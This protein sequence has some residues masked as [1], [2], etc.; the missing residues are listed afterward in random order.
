MARA[1]D[2]HETMVAVNFDDDANFRW[3][4][5]ILAHRLDDLRWVALS[6]DL[7]VLVLDLSRHIVVPVSRGAPYPARIAGNVYSTDQFDDAAL[8]TARQ[9][10]AALADVLRPAG[11]GAAG[12][13]AAAPALTMEWRFADTAFEKFGEIVPV[14]ISR[15]ALRMVIKGSAG[16]AEVEDN[17]ERFWTFVERVGN[18]DIE[19]WREEKTSGRGRDPRIMPI[20]RDMARARFAK[21]KDALAEMTFLDE[22]TLPADWPFPGPPAIKEILMAAR[23]ANEDL[24]GF[25]EYYIRASGLNPDHPVALKHRDLLSVLHHLI[26]FDQ[27]NAG[28]LAGAEMIA[29]LLLQIHQAVT[30]SPKNPVFQGTGLMVMSSLDSTG[31]VLTG[32]FARWT[33]DEQ[34]ARAFTMKQQRLYQ[35]EE[36]KR[37]GPKDTGSKGSKNEKDK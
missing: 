16:L 1:P 4:V 8:Q 18:Q 13:A 12:P 36:D 30:R 21:L 17:G 20:Q 26:A 19:E 25:H 28:Q 22:A 9:D 14:E 35:E 6:P 34:K 33:A 7:E 27:V 37:K 15:N 3:H 10:A 2:I 29:R 11:A 5:R 24:V 32:K 23:A 31:G